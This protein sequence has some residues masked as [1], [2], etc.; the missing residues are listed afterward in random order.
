MAQS[1]G[2]APGGETPPA[3]G[4]SFGCPGFALKHFVSCFSPNYGSGA[5]PGK[6]VPKQKGPN[7]GQKAQ[8]LDGA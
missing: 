8:V 5:G 7:T 4:D 6:S 1:D 3:H 2:S